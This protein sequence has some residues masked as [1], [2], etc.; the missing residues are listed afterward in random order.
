MAYTEVEGS[1][2]SLE[3]DEVKQIAEQHSNS[4]IH[5]DRVKFVRN[6][7]YTLFDV[8]DINQVLAKKYKIQSGSFIYVYPYDINDGY[9]HV[10]DGDPTRIQIDSSKGMIS[11]PIQETLMDPLFGQ[12]NSI[13]DRIIL[14]NS[15]DYE[16]IATH[17]DEYK[18]NGILH[19]YDFADWKH[20]GGIIDE[21]SK[22]LKELNGADK[23]DRFYQV[24]TRIEAYRTALQSSNF[25]TFT[26][27][28]VCLLLYFSVLTMFHFKLKMES[29]DDIKKYH[30]LYRIGLLEN[31]IKTMVNQK[32]RVIFL[33]PFGYA[34][35]ITLA[36]SYYVNSTYGYG[37]IGVFSALLTTFMFL[38]LHFVVYRRYVLVDYKQIISQISDLR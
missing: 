34:A 9:D 13:S 25:L 6:N 29:R 11:F 20:S 5:S 32:I 26:I 31:E 2:R 27:V 22:K 4:I 8:E 21:V 17:S 37:M 36:Y 38:C 18:I 30:G 33:I 12:I 14:V 16:W 28:Y 1:Y 23:G 7:I 35:V 19:L 15:L 24:S 3:D 10:Q